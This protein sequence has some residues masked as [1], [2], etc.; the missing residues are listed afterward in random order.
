[1][2]FSMSRR[3]VCRAAILAGVAICL[4]AVQACPA[5][6]VTYEGDDPTWATAWL[7]AGAEAYPEPSIDAVW[8]TGWRLHTPEGTYVPCADV[9]DANGDDAR[10]GLPARW[11]YDAIKL[12]QAWKLCPGN[13][14]FGITVGLF[15]TPVYYDH[16]DL[17]KPVFSQQEGEPKDGWL[18][19]NHGT[20]TAGI[21]AATANNGTGDWGGA[22]G[23]AYGCALANYSYSCPQAEALDG[24][25]QIFA[26]GVEALVK[27][28]ARVL[29]FS[30]GSSPD[31]L[32]AINEDKDE[33][34]RKALGD[35]NAELAER[36]GALLD[37]GYDFVICKAS[38][39]SN[40]PDDSHFE[41]PGFQ[42]GQKAQY[43][44]LSGIEDE[45]LLSRIIVVG[46]VEALSDGTCRVA[47]YSAGGPRVDVVAPGSY[48]YSPSPIVHGW[49]SGKATDG[50]F[51]EDGLFGTGIGA[52]D[53]G[54]EV[55]NGYSGGY[56]TSFAAPIVAGVAA[57]VWA[58]NP[59]LTGDQ[60]KNIV[61]TSA[62]QPVGYAQD[63]ASAITAF[64]GSLTYG[65][66]DAE[67]AVQ[68]AIDAGPG[69][70]V[71]EFSYVA[72]AG[73]YRGDVVIDAS[74]TAT[75][76]D[77]QSASPDYQVTSY[78]VSPADDVD[79]SALGAQARAWRFTPT[80]DG[81]MHSFEQDPDVV[82]GTVPVIEER[83][84]AYDPVTDTLSEWDSWGGGWL[85]PHAWARV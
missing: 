32:K 25:V 49:Q 39:N 50:L 28:G 62:T 57:M 73:G 24:I 18:A 1:M 8:N 16:E 5:R 55:G 70:P 11:A 42:G 6:A 9:H 4:P 80:G 54:D 51:G 46:G 10:V 75:F 72:M 40:S 47:P 48:V 20:H 30:N 63:V 85:D 65:L 74:G 21:I 68:A 61:C 33:V 45:R 3:D 17:P 52:A 58:T 77:V 44:L 2:S 56:G 53:S 81:E 82:T 34:K 43:D 27:N 35:W 29:N 59:S 83:I 26:D 69:T 71:G 41:S 7:N 78:Q 22:V 60:V 15:D 38:G 37:E 12:P 67:A 79:A 36:L 14:G 23:V 19:T 64:D 13:P 76:T 31:N 84:F 66:L